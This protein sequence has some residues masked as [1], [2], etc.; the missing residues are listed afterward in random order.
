MSEGDGVSSSAT[1]DGCG[2]ALPLA[3]SLCPHCGWDVTTAV[4]SGGRRRRLAS[5]T[6]AVRLLTLAVVLA[7]PVGGFLRLL[8]TG[9]GPDLATTLRWIACG[10]G[11]RAAELV[12]IHRAYEIASAAARYAV[13]ELSPPTFEDGW[14]GR[15]EPFATMN[16]RGWIPL[17]LVG[18]DTK[19]APAS[20]KEMYRVRAVDGWGRPYRVT[21]RLLARGAAWADDPEV[22]ADLA[23]GLNAS[24]FTL[25]RPDFTA[26]DHLRLEIRSAGADGIVDDADDLLL[27]TYVPVG[28]TFLVSADRQAIEAQLDAA[29][30][31]GRHYF[32]LEGNHW[33]LVDARLLAEFRLDCLS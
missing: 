13:R 16:V 24:L 29:Y 7:L 12:T 5:L 27:V 4:I 18:A 2:E 20:V 17:L 25:G 3:A 14:A 28:F 33:D 21:D 15:L 32:R 19:L 23:A 10:D 8:A 1:C 31:L 6:A 9:P 11:G 26:A 22:A 30:F